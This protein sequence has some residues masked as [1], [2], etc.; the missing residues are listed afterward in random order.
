M[1]GD[2]KVVEIPVGGS[3]QEPGIPATASDT[4]T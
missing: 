2:D 1:D 3:S 4:L